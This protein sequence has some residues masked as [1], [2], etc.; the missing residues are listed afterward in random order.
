[1]SELL[2][3]IRKQPNVFAAIVEH[4]SRTGRPELERAVTLL[5]SSSR[6]AFLAIGRSRYAAMAS[7]LYLSRKGI[8]ARVVDASELLYYDALPESTAVLVSRSGRTAEMVRVAERFR[9]MK[10]PYIAVTNVPEPNGHYG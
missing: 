8:D 5:R 4:L 2:E 6:V 7:A 3:N 10:R 9:E 1:M